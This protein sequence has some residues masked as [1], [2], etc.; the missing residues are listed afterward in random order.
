L[1]V[2]VTGP[3]RK[4]MKRH[5]AAEIAT[6]LQQAQEFIARGQSQAEAC[7]ALGVSVMTYHRWRKLPP[8]T[9]GEELVLV[10]PAA[11]AAE[12]NDASVDQKRI[13]E[14]RLENQRLRRIVTDLLLEKV[15]VEEMA[16]NPRGKRLAHN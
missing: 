13:D 5:S 11:P 10:E 16:L 3:E 4:K 7:K 9:N 1:V 2:V 15:K 8:S 12:A 14:L 6:K